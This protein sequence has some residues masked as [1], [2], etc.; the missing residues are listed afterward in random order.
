VVLKNNIAFCGVVDDGEG[1]VGWNCWQWWQIA[2]YYI[3]FLEASVTLLNLP[4]K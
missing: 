1:E 2:S 4:H 3:L